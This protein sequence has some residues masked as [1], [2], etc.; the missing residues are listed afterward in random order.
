MAFIDFLLS[1]ASDSGEEQLR[2]AVAVCVAEGGS[3][4]EI[5]SI[6]DEFK[7]E[8][9]KIPNG[10]NIGLGFVWNSDRDCAL[11]DDYISYIRRVY[12]AES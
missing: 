1:I 6:A 8:L 10:A 5:R 11:I 2:A 12:C 3:F 4:N 7:Q 9:R